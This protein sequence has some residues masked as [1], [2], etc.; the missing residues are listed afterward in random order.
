MADEIEWTPVKVKLGDLSHWA[1]NPVTLSKAQAKKLLRSKEKL[2]KMQTLA[3][4]PSNGDGKYPLY[5]GHQ[6]ANVWG[7]AF[8]M[9][10]EVWALQSSRAL[11]DEERH[12]VP[13][14]LR[15]AVGSLDW[16]ALAG[17][18]DYPISEWGLD[19]D[20]LQGLKF[21]IA[22]LGNLLE[23][24]TPEPA[25]AEPQIDRAEE[26]NKK[27]QVKAGDLWRIGEHRLL[28]GDSTRREDVERVMQGIQSTLM[29]TDPPYG[30]KYD[31]TWREDAG[32]STAG[33]QS[34]HDIE[35]D[36]NADWRGAYKL[37]GVDIAYIW[38][39]TIFSRLVADGLES[40]GFV[41]KQQIIWNKTVAAFGRS[42]YSYK[43]EP[44]WYAV[45]KGKTSRWCGPTNEV[46]VWDIASPRH[47][48]GGSDEEKQPHSTQK[49]LECMARPIRNHD[50]LEVY[51][52][53]VGSGTT[54]VACQNL[55]RKC[56]AIEIS[57]AYCSVSLQRMQD[58]FPDLTIERID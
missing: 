20:A 46:T 35:W 29:V 27:W 1:D 16:D 18:T 54:I 28:C 41:V 49:P 51:D 33:P 5:D 48:M 43:H 24:E 17:W 23:S 9:G 53:F 44:C 40:A 7:A 6:R 14:M 22:A 47:I 15:T 19:D 30:I 37:S 10:L 26:L 25:D 58:A 2:G 4:G 52:P 42:H 32:I 13:I 36:E 38:H 50:A 8:G 34:A 12:A 3:I 11:T 57:P 21:D 56:R 55:R 45:R 31:T 39:A